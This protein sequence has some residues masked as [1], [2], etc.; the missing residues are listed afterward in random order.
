MKKLML[1]FI[2]L[3]FVVGCEDEIKINNVNT[4]ATSSTILVEIK[5]AVKYPG[6]YEIEAGSIVKD[7][8]DLA[9]GVLPYA[10]LASVNVVTKLDANQLVVIPTNTSVQTK[11]NINVAG[12]EE[13]TT[14]E[15]IGTTKANAIIK[16]RNEVGVFTSIEELK[17]VSGISSN[18]FE[19]IKAFITVQ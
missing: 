15:G 16:Y 11:I 2:C 17:K 1:L 3:M 4:E 19:K 9:G 8:I 13:L 6:V 12:I 14:I 10:N 7:L 18:L 5:G